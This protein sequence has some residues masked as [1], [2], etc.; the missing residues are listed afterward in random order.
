MAACIDLTKLKSPGLA[1][2]ISTAVPSASNAYALAERPLAARSP[3][4][5]SLVLALLLI[6]ISP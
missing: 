2:R 6:V 4:R 1:E 3:P 5:P